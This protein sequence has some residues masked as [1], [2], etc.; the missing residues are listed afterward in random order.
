MAD[1]IQNTALVQDTAVKMPAASTDIHMSF[2]IFRNMNCRKQR[3]R[4]K[5]GG[6]QGR[7][8][9]LCVGKHVARTIILQ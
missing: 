7:K 4:Q 3:S 6:A 2:V 1:P 9:Y 5:L 8:N